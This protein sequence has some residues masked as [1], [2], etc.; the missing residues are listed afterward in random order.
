MNLTMILREEM[1][2]LAVQEDKSLPLWVYGED[3][4]EILAEQPTVDLGNILDISPEDFTLVDGDGSKINIKLD[5]KAI[6]KI[7]WAFLKAA[8][9]FLFMRVEE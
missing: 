7:K 3:G 9:K 1:P 8:I 5:R 2:G 4:I 6:W